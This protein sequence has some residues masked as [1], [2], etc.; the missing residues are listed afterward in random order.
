MR[1]ISLVF[2]V[3]ITLNVILKKP[4]PW[5]GALGFAYINT[6]L[7]AREPAFAGRAT[8]LNKEVSLEESFLQSHFTKNTL[9]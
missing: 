1:L 9:Q 5:A 3:V 4:N 2:C 6:T 7:P 8:K